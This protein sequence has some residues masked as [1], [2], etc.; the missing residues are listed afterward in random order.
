METVVDACSPSGERT[1]SMHASTQ[2]M[3]CMHPMYASNVCMHTSICAGGRPA[4][5]LG[6]SVRRQRL[7]SSLAAAAM[8]DALTAAAEHS[9]ACT[10]VRVRGGVRLL[11][12]WM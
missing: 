8:A 10:W 1:C 9:E 12:G 11:V 5:P 7:P 6:S 3:Q 4:V 2:C